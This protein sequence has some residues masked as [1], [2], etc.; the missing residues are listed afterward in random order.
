LFSHC[1]KIDRICAFATKEE[2]FDYCG[3]ATNE[4][5]IQL[6]VKCP[7]KPKKRWGR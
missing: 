2:D 7:K 1:I 5:R 3:L 6:M 4:N